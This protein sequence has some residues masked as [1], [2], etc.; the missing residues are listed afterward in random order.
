MRRHRKRLLE[1]A[2]LVLFGLAV[3]QANVLWQS[4][5][6]R[7]AIAETG[8]VALSLDQALPLSAETEKPVLVELAAVWCPSCRAMDR[9]VLSDPAVRA[10]IEQDFHF[11]RLEYESE[12]GEAFR[13]RHGVHGFPRFFV[14]DP[15]GEILRRVSAIVDPRDFEQQLQ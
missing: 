12:A 6:G 1:L 5:L 2:G 11:V 3:Y 13:A 8:L 10:R 7:A 9:Q 15:D 4:H 14:L